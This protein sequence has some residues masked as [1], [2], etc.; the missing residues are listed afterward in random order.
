M[1]SI[2]ISHLKEYRKA[3]KRHEKSP[4]S[5]VDSLYKKSHPVSIPENQLQSADH[6]TNV[7]RVIL[8]ELVPWE[9]WD[10][11]HSELLVRI[12][13]KKLDSFIENTLTDPAWLNDKLLTLLKGKEELVI[14]SEENSSKVEE[15]KADVTEVKEEIATESQIERPTVETALSTLITKTTAP[16]LQRAINEE[17]QDDTVS[18]AS[19]PQLASVAEEVAVSSTDPVDIKSSPV[20][21]QRR[22]RQGRNEVKIYDRIIEGEFMLFINKFFSD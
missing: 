1:C 15:E 6:C 12:L 18:E 11:P 13:S 22:G 2:L 16:I 8:K 14:V 5:S 7:M 9:L 17:F 4:A 21:R 10:T 19:E 20:L 3:L